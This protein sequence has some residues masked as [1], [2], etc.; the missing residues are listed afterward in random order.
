L[1]KLA[2]FKPPGWVAFIETLPTTY[3]QKLRKG[4]ILS[5]IDPRGHPAAVD[6]RY[7]KHT[8]GRDK[9]PAADVRH[10]E[11]VSQ[12]PVVRF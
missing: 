4:V 2:N 9:T 3:S 8:R 7:I 12:Q 11:L 6:V 5:E 1:E 10:S